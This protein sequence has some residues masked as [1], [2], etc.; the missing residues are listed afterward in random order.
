MK[1]SLIQL[2][3]L[4]ALALCGTAFADTEADAADTGSELQTVHVTAE[5]QAKQQLGVS[6]IT[7]QDLQKI[8]V[9]NDISEI[10]SKMPGVN[11]STNSPGGERG[12]KRQ[13]DIRSMDPDNTLILIDGKPVN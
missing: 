8:P 7:A 9:T 12:N 6:V 2:N 3:I 4:A 11:L 10:V 5:R 1:P 13:I